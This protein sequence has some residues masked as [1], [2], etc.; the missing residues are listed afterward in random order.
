M[1]VWDELNIGTENWIIKE[2]EDIIRE[3]SP[4]EMDCIKWSID[5][6]SKNE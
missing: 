2:L 4:L 1:Y 6:I 3:D 5:F